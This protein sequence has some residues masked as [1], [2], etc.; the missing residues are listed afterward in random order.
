M[1][2]AGTNH[3][4]QRF[5]PRRMEALKKQSGTMF[6]ENQQGLKLKGSRRNSLLLPETW[7]FGEILIS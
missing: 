3:R 2:A 6:M 4:H 1:G 7:H 5:L